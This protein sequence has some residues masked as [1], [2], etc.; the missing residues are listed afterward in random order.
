MLAHNKEPWDAIAEMLRVTK[1][2]GVVAIR[3]GDTDSEIWWPDDIGMQK[4]H[5]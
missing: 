3:E 2:G 5:E 1:P 4:C